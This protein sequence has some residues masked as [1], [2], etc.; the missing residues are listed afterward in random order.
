MFVA[1]YSVSKFLKRLQWHEIDSIEGKKTSKKLYGKDCDCEF[2]FGRD[3]QC[4]CGW[5]KKVTIDE[6]NSFNALRIVS[7]ARVQRQN[8]SVFRFSGRSWWESVI[9]YTVYGVNYTDST[10][11]FDHHLILY[12]VWTSILF[13]IKIEI[14]PS[15]LSTRLHEF[16]WIITSFNR[17]A[18]FCNV[19]STNYLSLTHRD[20]ISTITAESIKWKNMSLLII[21][22]E[23][24]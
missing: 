14:S 18:I 5:R 7:K 22:Y 9:R 8:L 2:E 11:I 21:W 6:Q 16:N 10:L 1:E 17:P 3:F 19:D 15:V 12:Q 4:V 20:I 23:M 13:N 24:I